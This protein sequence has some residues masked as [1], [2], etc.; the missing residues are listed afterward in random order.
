MF[1]TLFNALKLPDLRKKLLV[2][3]ALLIVFRFGSFITAPGVDGEALA[4]L[5]SE[6]SSSILTTINVVTGGA[7]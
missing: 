2:T 6:S 7:F 1:K 5:M 4:S 3:L